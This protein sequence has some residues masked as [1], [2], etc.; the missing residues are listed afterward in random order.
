MSHFGSSNA[1][2]DKSVRLVGRLSCVTM[3]NSN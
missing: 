1:K 3:A 2:S